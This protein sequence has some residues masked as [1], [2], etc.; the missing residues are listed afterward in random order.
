MSKYAIFPPNLLAKSI[1][2]S[3]YKTTAHAVAE[4]IDNSVQAKSDLVEVFCV[5]ESQLVEKRRWHRVVEI[6]VLD[7]GSGMNAEVLRNALMF[8]NGMYLNDRSGIGRFGMGLPNSSLSQ[9]Q[10]IEVWSWQAGPD[11]ALYSYLDVRRISDG[12][13]REVPNPDAKPVPMKWRAVAESHL[14][15]SGT[16][17]VWSELDRVNWRGAQSTFKHTELLVGRIYRKMIHDD[18]LRIRLV[19]VRDDDVQ[20]ET[21]VRVNDPL[22]LMSPSSTPAPFDDRPMFRPWG[23]GEERITVKLEGRDH[24]ITI[25][26]SWASEEAMSPESG[27]VDPGHHDYGKHALKNRGISVVRARRELDLDTSWNRGDIYRDRWWGIEVEFPPA[28]DEIFGVTNNKQA[29][30]HFAELAEFFADE[31]RQGEWQELRE[32]WKEDGDLRFYLT[33]VAQHIAEQRNQMRL[34]LKQ[35]RRGAR[36]RKI[37]SRHAP[38]VEDRA[39]D[40]IRERQKEA[41]ADVVDEPTTPDKNYETVLEELTTTAGMTERDARE[42][43]EAVRIRD[44]K[45]IFVETDEDSNAFFSVKALPGIHEVRINLNHPVHK[46]LIEALD[47]ELEED[48][49]ELRVRLRKASDTLKLLLCAW[50]RFELEARDPPRRRIAEHR[51]EWGKMATIFLDEDLED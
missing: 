29:A 35:M 48:S 13:M 33:D 14:G 34:R 44:R 24:I 2:D 32:I 42:I 12:E 45:I 26:S 51:R 30:T 31:E 40:K 20:W 47:I 11:N 19:A 10:H 49:E 9:C 18:G 25:R 43:A 5:E 27:P 46:L 7:N 50:S 3:G 21:D 39:S 4:L 38:T 28:L 22:F 17:V 16:L 37:E 1:R 41:R 15:E 6:A 23:K 8:G 36:Q